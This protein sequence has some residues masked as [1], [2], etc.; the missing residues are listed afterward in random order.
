MKTVQ[1]FTKKQFGRNRNYILN[2]DQKLAHAQLT[3]LKVMTD[4]NMMAYRELGVI[5]EQV[6]IPDDFESVHLP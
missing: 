6:A 1:F 3:N 2:P 4:G 5:F